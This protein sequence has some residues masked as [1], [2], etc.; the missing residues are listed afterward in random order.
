MVFTGRIPYDDVPLYLR[1][2][3]IA[4]STQTNNLPGQVRTTGKLPEYMAAERFILASRVGEAALLLPEVMLVDYE[5]EL[6]SAYPS[7]LAQRIRLLHRHR[8]LLEVRLR[9][10]EVARRLC[11]YDVLSLACAD[12]IR[13]AARTQL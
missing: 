6:D 2:M 4:L 13:R 5:G 8:S 11:S 3:D 1:M 12:V 10:P 7:R 9:L